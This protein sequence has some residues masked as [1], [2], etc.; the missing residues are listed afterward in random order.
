MMNTISSGEGLII[1]KYIR[2]FS[3][4]GK[5]I[6]GSPDISRKD[7]LV[8]QHPREPGLV[9][10]KRCIGMP[11]D[12]LMINKNAVYI[13]GSLDTEPENAQFSYAIKWATVGA[14]NFIMDH[15]DSRREEYF[16]E[17]AFV[18]SLTKADSVMLSKKEG[19]TRIVRLNNYGF[20][21][22]IFPAD[23]LHRWNR[24]NFGP[25]S[26]PK[27]KLTLT[28]TADN[29]SLY[30]DAICADSVNIVKVIQKKIYLN[31]R[32]I[33]SYQFK[34][35]FYFMMGDNR[36]D[37]IDSRYWGFVPEDKIVGK[38]IY[39]ITGSGPLGFSIKQL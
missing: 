3:F 26:I 13:N 37:S 2:G 25:L 29:I 6:G 34:N 4:M 22:S 9:L 32:Q 8:F 21:H 5:K 15:F 16:T 18:V 30:V 38:A 14:Y 17:K 10:V 20:D 39:K 31:G 23:S 28:L 24:D 27:K 12:E 36:H 33:H 11:G 35:N 1:H 7:I 19:I